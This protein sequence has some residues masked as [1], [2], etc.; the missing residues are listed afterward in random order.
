MG[1]FDYNSD[2]ANEMVEIKQMVFEKIAKSAS[3]TASPSIMDQ[4]EIHQQRDFLTD[5]IV[6]TITTNIL[7]QKIHE[8]KEKIAFIY[9]FPSNWWEHLKADHAPQWFIKKYPIKYTEHRKE[10]TLTFTRYA[11]YPKA[12]ILVQ[13]NKKLFIDF[14]GGTEVIVDEVR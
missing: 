14:L 10:R 3:F 8:D 7:R 1:I 6:Y 4:L 9:S 2:L 5:G 12:N 13:E 11:E